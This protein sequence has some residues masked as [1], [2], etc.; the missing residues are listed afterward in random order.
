MNEEIQLSKRQQKIINLIAVFFIVAGSLSLVNILVSA[1][2]LNKGV[3][4]FS[5]FFIF[6][7]R[8]MLQRRNGFYA[9]GKFVVSVSFIG[10]AIGLVLFTFIH[11]K[12]PFISLKIIFFILLIAYTTLA[13]LMF[14]FLS[15][16]QIVRYFKTTKRIEKT[17][18]LRTFIISLSIILPLSFG[19]GWLI[20]TQIKKI[21]DRPKTEYTI[22]AV[23]ADT[24]KK[25]TCI[26]AH[27]G[28]IEQPPPKNILV[29]LTDRSGFISTG[30]GSGVDRMFFS[31]PSYRDY[32]LNI[33]K[34]GYKSKRVTLIG[35]KNKT[36]TVKL[37]KEKDEDLEF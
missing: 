7:G 8:G 2:F 29:F 23:D 1:I 22:I 5:V 33:A 26:G 4:D 27:N 32:I 28:N 16:E 15:N 35:G 34:D 31:F 24:N 36:I 37:K 21:K 9:F 13:Y 30:A 11:Y 19:S 14:K 12:V 10:G 6:V 25:I 17:N 18:F 20:K 3:F